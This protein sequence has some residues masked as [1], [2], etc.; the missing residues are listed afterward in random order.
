MRL[1]HLVSLEW[2]KD[3]LHMPDVRVIDCRF[4]L[5]HPERGQEDYRSGHIPG[6]FFLDLDK[7]LSSPKQAHGGRH[8]LPDMEEFAEKLSRLGID[9]TVKVVAYDD[10]GGM[11]ATRLWWMLQYLGHQEAYVLDGGFTQW[12]EN[13]YPVSVEIPA[14]EP[15]T[16]TAIPKQE[17]WVSMEEVKERIGQPGTIIVDA[18]E[19]RRYQGLEEPIDP[20]A[21]HIPGAVNYFWKDNLT[22]EGYWKSAE[23]QKDRYAELDPTKEIIV[24]CGSGVSSCPN[25]LSLQSLGYSNVKLYIGSWSDWCSYPENPVGKKVK[26]E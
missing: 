5:L 22:N 14:V 1:Q 2:L 9:D 7:D 11:V 6:A 26:T 10:Q 3:S 24:Y 17:M 25:I 8:P 4:E 20:V 19:D 15:R 21:G 12:K 13:G 18:R 16:F 23:E